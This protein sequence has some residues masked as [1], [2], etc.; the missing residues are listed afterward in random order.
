MAE[1]EGTSAIGHG[2]AKMIVVRSLNL[3]YVYIRN[4]LVIG[5]LENIE[6]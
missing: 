5:K 2:E 6:K 4:M 1:V 3:K